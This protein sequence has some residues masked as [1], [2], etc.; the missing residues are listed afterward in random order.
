M[1]KL[2]VSGCALAVLALGLLPALAAGDMPGADA[3]AL[4]KYITQTSPYKKWGQFPD[5]MG[6]QSSK[7]VHGT[8]VQIWANQPVLTAKQV[9]LPDGS[10]IVKEGMGDDKKANVVVV[11]Y[12]I[13]GFNPEAGDWFW[14][15]YDL[16]GKV[17]AAGKVAPCI[18]CHGAKAA[19][20]YVAAHTFK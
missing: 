3:A 18:S 7:A 8:N 15:K 9:P 2:L 6:V 10:I 14:A 16:D 11:M 1:K 17:G 12:K 4:W 19:N 20:D 5:K 13:K